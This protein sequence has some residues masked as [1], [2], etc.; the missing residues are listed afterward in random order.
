MARVPVSIGDVR[1][2]GLAVG[3]EIVHPGGTRPDRATAVA[4]RD[5]M[6]ARGV[7]VGTTGRT[8]NVL[9]V[10]PPLAFTDRELPVFVDALDSALAEQSGR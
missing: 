3:V 10:R 4:V 9:K 7:L 2:A 6:R 5:G 1:G 8:G